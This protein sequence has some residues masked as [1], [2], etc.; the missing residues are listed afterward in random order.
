[1]DR[2][3]EPQVLEAFLAGQDALCP[4]CGYNLRG[5]QADKCPECGERLELG[6]VKRRRL[7]GWAPFLVLVFGWLL[8]AGGIN[9]AR[10]VQRLVRERDAVAVSNQRIAAAQAQL[11]ARLKQMEERLVEE[12][13]PA[14]PSKP[15]GLS[16]LALRMQE[17]S[18]RELRA[19]IQSQQAAVTQLMRQQLAMSA[20]NTPGVRP[21]PTLGQAWAGGTVLQ[22]AGSIWSASL[23]VLSLLGLVLTVV[24]AARR[25]SRAGALVWMAWVMFLFYA[26]W[27]VSLFVRELA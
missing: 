4:R 3:G 27:H 12:T 19:M 23:A 6:L 9:T 16:D 18:S 1:M 26:G 11:Q 10:E 24:L 13:A 21:V 25:T 7:G 14:A 15:A 22:K 2:P 5:A 17:R 20:R 8:I